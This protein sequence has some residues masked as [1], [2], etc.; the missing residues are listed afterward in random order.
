[1]GL[2]KELAEKYRRVAIVGM[3]KNA[4]KTTTLNLLVEEAMDEGMLIGVTSTGRD[5]ENTDL[6]TGT[7][8][9]R[10][11]LDAGTIVSVPVQIYELSEAGLEIL[12]MTDY[13]TVLGQLMICRVAE[14]G[15]VQVAGPVNTKDH[16]KLCD[17]MLSFGCEILL[18]DGAVDRRS[19]ASPDSADAIILATGAAV[20]R[21]MKKM[22]E[23]TLHVVNLFQLPEL[24]DSE[25]IKVL[26]DDRTLEKIQLISKS[27]GK[28]RMKELELDTG[29]MASN[30]LDQAIGDETE[31]VFL[32]GALTAGVLTDIHP[33]KLGRLTFVLKDP[34]KIFIGVKHWQQLAKKGLKVK[35][36]K[37]IKVA[38]V[39]VNPY[40]PAG[41]S[42][43][44]EELLKTMQNALGDMPV[45]NVRF[46]PGSSVC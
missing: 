6:V 30:T 24:E 10:V 43:D 17:E 34:T 16:E 32:P 25:I 35:V 40:A 22:V 14:S 31:Y 11:Y 26:S 1:M 29:L 38:A 5:G 7:E 15:Y 12:K 44:Q 19:I 18:I 46:S 39:T 41:Y 36:I 8:K 4:G 13:Y 23:E 27:G 2:I 45:I 28:V 9:P 20:S 42:F 3:S 37:N 21:N 33:K